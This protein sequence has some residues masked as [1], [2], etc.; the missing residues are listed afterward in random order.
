M[1]PTRATK[2]PRPRT[3]PLPAMAHRRTTMTPGRDGVEVPCA[4]QPMRQH[5]PPM[6]LHTHSHGPRPR[7]LSSRNRKARWRGA[8]VGAG[9]EESARKPARKPAQAQEQ[10]SWRLLLQDLLIC[11]E[12]W[13]RWRNAYPPAPEAGYVQGQAC[14]PAA[15]AARHWPLQNRSQGMRPMPNDMKRNK[16][17]T[18][19]LCW[20]CACK[21]NCNLERNAQVSFERSSPALGFA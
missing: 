8:S 18:S 5:R 6:R 17:T 14:A 19:T 9:V 15:G 16:V 11:V 10:D 4:P 13:A 20:R 21:S 1:P 3:C 2:S 7:R 12:A